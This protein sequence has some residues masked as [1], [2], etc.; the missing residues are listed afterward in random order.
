MS[1]SNPL[2]TV[3]V[4]HKL[5]PLVFFFTLLELLILCVIL[6]MPNS[7][8]YRE[9]VEFGILTNWPWTIVFGCLLVHI[10]IVRKTKLL[11]VPPL[12]SSGQALNAISWSCIGFIHLNTPLTGG[13]E[14]ASG[15]F[16]LAIVNVVIA[17]W[18]ELYG[19]REI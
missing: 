11:H 6:K 2:P 4:E 1:T 18:I 14:V 19:H 16:V 12:V 3:T 8:V 9:L 13:I 7:D 17:I 15:F 5:R 10:G